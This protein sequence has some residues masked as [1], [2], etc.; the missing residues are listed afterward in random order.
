MN[1]YRYA[2]NRCRSNDC[3]KPIFK[4]GLCSAC[5]RKQYFQLFNKQ[6]LIKKGTTK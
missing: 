1:Y 3:G 6:R 2:V 5:E 4:P